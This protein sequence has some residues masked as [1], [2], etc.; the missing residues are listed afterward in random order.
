MYEL[1][2]LGTHTYYIQCPA[3]IGVYRTD[4][5]DVYLIDSGND[6]EA[7]RRVRKILDENGWRL[8]AIINTHSNADHIGGNRYLQQQTG[9][10]VFAKGIEKAF[11]EFPILEPA[12]LYGG[13]PCR[14]LRHK[15]LLAAQSEVTPITDPSFPQELEILDLPGHFF[16]MIGIRTPDDVVFL[17]DCV[18]SAD[19]LNKYQISFLY[20]V[21]AYLETLDKVEQL[22]AA[23]FVPAHAD[24]A[25]D[26]KELVR[27]NRD[28][29]QE[30]AGKLLDVL[31]TPMCFETLL[32]HI[33]D[34]YSLTMTFEQYALVGSTVRS[35]LSWL[36]DS[37]KAEAR[38]EENY[39]LWQ[40]VQ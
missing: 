21:T 37:G 39:V 18:S 9:C 1:H 2:Q 29:V 36:K 23:M 22:S 24:A 17:A 35:Y 38:F 6:K 13:Y 15:F 7:G 8:K 33:F 20:D 10:Q 27:K 14:D 30:I 19:T 32:K 31:K 16:D 26:V 25:P 34:D 12:F 3:K 40:S 11:T 4:A 5:D 28:K